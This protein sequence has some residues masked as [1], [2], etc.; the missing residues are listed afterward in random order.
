MLRYHILLLKMVLKTF[1]DQELINIFRR[2]YLDNR[3]V[4]HWNRIKPTGTSYEHFRMVCE[5]CWWLHKNNIPFCTEAQFSSR[6]CPDVLCPSHVKP[7][8]EV[9]SSESNEESDAKFARIPTELHDKI[10][11]V[12]ANEEF[13]EKMI[14]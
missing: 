9:R 3:R 7:I 6:Y 2:K 5:I 14:L 10:I 12:E 11:F 8:I 1:R 13:S 4:F